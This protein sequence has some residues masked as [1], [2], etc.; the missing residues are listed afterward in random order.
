FDI[1]LRSHFAPLPDSQLVQRPLTREDIVL[2]AAPAY[3]RRRGA[4]RWPQELTA[5]DAL[6]TGPA[7][8]TW[9]LR[10]NDEDEAVEVAPRPRMVADESMVLLQGAR[11]GLGVT[12]LPAAMC[13]AAIARG[14]LAR[15]L[16]GWSAGSVATTILMP[17]RRGQLPAVRAVVDF[18]CARCAEPQP[19][20]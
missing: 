17:H 11:A 10:Q 9:Q 15:V 7:A 2:V 14:D 20:G 3:L 6:L 18:L 4:P 8:T 12:C 19:L 1:A 5:H 16:P 13:R